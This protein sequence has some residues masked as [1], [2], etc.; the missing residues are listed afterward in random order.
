MNGRVSTVTCQLE[1]QLQV[2]GDASV[3]VPVTLRYEAHDPYAVHAT[4]ETGAEEG[5]SWT[6]ARE[7]LAQGVLRAAGEGDVRVWPSWRSGLDVVYVALASPDGEAL[8]EAPAAALVSFLRRTYVV[9]P[10]GDESAHL[11][12][13]STVEA[14]L[15]G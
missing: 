3:P 7:L 8:L 12:L 11:D 10:V 14:L 13:D 5:V 9:V 6:F 15:A 1:V 4:F 2:S